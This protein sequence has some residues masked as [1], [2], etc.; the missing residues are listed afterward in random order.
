MTELCLAAALLTARQL[1][2]RARRPLSAR[3]G[4]DATRGAAVPGA[5]L[6]ARREL[7]SLPDLRVGLEAT[8]TFLGMSDELLLD[9]VRTRR[10]CASS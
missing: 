7:S 8:G 4:A 1:R 3:D 2:R 10:S 9:R 6:G 5:P